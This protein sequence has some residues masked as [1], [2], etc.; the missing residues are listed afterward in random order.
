MPSSDAL[1][2][3]NI[4]VHVAAGSLALLLG[5]V[6]LAL[7]KG[8]RRHR[9]LG[10]VTLAIVGVAVAAAIVGAFVWRG[11]F[12]LMGVS[13]LS[14]YQ[15]WAG[16]RALRLR[17]A[18]R[19]FI[20]LGP[21]IAVVALGVLGLWLYRHSTAF[22]W[23]PGLV[24]GTI[25]GLLVY[26]GWDVVRAGFPIG[27]RQVLNPAEHAFRM[28]SLIGALA[29]VAAGTVL[30]GATVYVSLAASGVL[31]VLAVVLAVR[32]G[33]RAWRYADGVTPSASLKAR[34][35]TDSEA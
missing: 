8:D 4:L 12:D 9:A 2:H 24:Y 34:L 32:A 13:V 1:H 31:G 25:G 28:T 15:M 26:G 11:R 5:L 16:V 22:N 7:R 20:D 14:A 3:I 35:N 6:M 27:W 29:S 33:R 18:G 21:A 30:K 19:R 10:R 23:S 17:Q